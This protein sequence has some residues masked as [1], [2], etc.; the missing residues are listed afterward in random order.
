MS[1][2][3]LIKEDIAAKNYDK[4]SEHVR[5]IL[6]KIERDYSTIAFFDH[7][8]IL[9]FDLAGDLSQ[10]VDISDR[11]YFNKARQGLSAVT[12]PLYSEYSQKNIIVIS[13]PIF[14]YRQFLGLIAMTM[15]ADTA[16]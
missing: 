12:G 9:K 2:N 14:Q 1:A 7:H 6:E 4:A 10:K 3:P 16:I 5:P 13:S 11:D 8:G 15:D